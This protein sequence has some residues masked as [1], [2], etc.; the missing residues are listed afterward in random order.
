[1][2]YFLVLLLYTTSYAQNLDSL[3][4]VYN[5]NMLIVQTRRGGWTPI[6]GYN[7]INEAQFFSIA[8][9]DREAQIVRSKKAFGKKL[10]ITGIGFA[11]LGGVLIENYRDRNIKIQ[12]DVGFARTNPP[13]TV[14]EEEN[15]KLRNVG[16]FGIGA[17]IVFGMI[18]GKKI[19]SNWATKERAE[20]IVYLYNKKLRKQLGLRP[21]K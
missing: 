3:E 8:D 15:R 4:S 6:L 14:T 13:K 17:G 16:Y 12:E 2:R 1:M 11:V 10:L 20:E 7:P 21:N 5:S 19:S 9:M 18:G